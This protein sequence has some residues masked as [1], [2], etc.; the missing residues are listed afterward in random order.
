MPTNRLVY[1]YSIKA[2]IRRCKR[3]VQKSP[4]KHTHI[5]LCKSA[6]NSLTYIFKSWDSFDK[7]NSTTKLITVYSEAK[8]SLDSC[9]SLPKQNTHRRRFP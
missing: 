4:F 1:P 8:T 5:N 2:R 7:S 9:L 3:S 6:S